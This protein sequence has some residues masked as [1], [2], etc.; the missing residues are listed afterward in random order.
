MQQPYIVVVPLVPVFFVEA[1]PPPLSLPPPVMPVSAMPLATR[2]PTPP[3]ATR[4][5]T[6]PAESS[7]SKP[8]TSSSANWKLPPMHPA[9]NM[10]WDVLGEPR[11]AYPE[12]ARTNPSPT[13]KRRVNPALLDYDRVWRA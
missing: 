11:R 7:P 1:V 9:W 3:V 10:A 12:H 5:P 13:P 6:P 2:T 8:K 4:T